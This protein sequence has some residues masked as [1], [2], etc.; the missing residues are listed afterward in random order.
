MA[1]DARLEPLKSQVDS[2]L[3]ALRV[4]GYAPPAVTYRRWIL[5]SLWWA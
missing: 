2:V 3:D 1:A 5:A 4:A